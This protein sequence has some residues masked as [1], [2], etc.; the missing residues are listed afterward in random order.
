MLIKILSSLIFLITSL[1]CNTKVENDATQK[2]VITEISVSQA[3]S[4]I[5]NTKGLIILDVRTPEETAQG[6]IKGAIIIDIA[7]NDFKDKVQKLD[8]TKPILVYCKAGGRSSTATE[9]MEELGFKKLYNLTEGYDE[10]KS[11]KN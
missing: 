3:K 4:L 10:W 5:K 7:R 6:I 2:P 8:K 9:I 11:V 1:D